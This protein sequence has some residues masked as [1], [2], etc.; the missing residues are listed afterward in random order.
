MQSRTCRTSFRHFCKWTSPCIFL[1]WPHLA[2]ASDAPDGPVLATDSAIAAPDASVQAL[3]S[4]IDSQ[5]EQAVR[6]FKAGDYVKSLTRFMSLTGRTPS[7]NVQLY[8]GYCHV[9]LDHP[10]EAHQAF[11]LV[12]WQIEKLGGTEYETTRSAA[13]E[14]LMALAPKLSQLTISL[15]R[16]PPYAAVRLDGL[17]VEASRLGSPM[18]LE[19]GIHVVE[20]TAPDADA[21]VQSVAI[22][23]GGKK[24]V[25]LML[26]ARVETPSLSTRSN[27]RASVSG[28][29]DSSRYSM[30][31]WAAAGLGVTGWGLFTVGGLRAKSTYADLQEQCASRCSD[32]THRQAVADGQAWQTVANIGLAVGIVGTVSAA[33]LF[34]IGSVSGA[35][36]PT[37]AR[38]RLGSSFGQVSYEGRF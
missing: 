29:A 4:D 32:A 13:E 23:K 16:S 3:D 2:S 28:D 31:A 26:P 11:S 18:A 9:R 8:I 25:V 10:V 19:P 38:L 30:Y 21:I 6:L 34:G 37:T 17:P 7:P 15:V 33:T 36:Q 1:A 14:Q 24:T 12:L 35:D 20:V 27:E 5:F 22:E